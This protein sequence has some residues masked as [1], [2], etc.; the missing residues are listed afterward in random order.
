M[1]ITTP[2]SVEYEHDIRAETSKNGVCGYPPP[3]A[4]QYWWPSGGISKKRHISPLPRGAWPRCQRWR[5]HNPLAPEGPAIIRLYRADP[6]AIGAG[7][8]AGLKEPTGV[9]QNTVGAPPRCHGTSRWIPEVAAHHSPG[10]RDSGADLDRNWRP[11]GTETGLKRPCSPNARKRRGG[12]DLIGVGGGGM[13]RALVETRR[14]WGESSG[15]QDRRERLRPI[16]QNTRRLGGRAG[17][18]GSGPGLIWADPRTR[19]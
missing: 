2:V 16:E 12:S 15:S 1:R 3:R 19:P 6:R 14:L 11:P 13:A 5:T 10:A 7:K 18:R 17:T 4:L 9:P 8:T